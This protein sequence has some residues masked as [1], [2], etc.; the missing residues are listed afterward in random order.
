MAEQ[1][2]EKQPELPQGSSLTDQ[3]LT[4]LGLWLKRLDA[5]R[6]LVIAETRLNLRALAVFTALIITAALVVISIWLSMLACIGVMAYWLLKS[7]LLALAI[8][9]IFQWLVL[10]RLLANIRRVYIKMGYQR[11]TDALSA[12][13]SPTPDDSDVAGKHNHAD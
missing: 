2:I 4:I 5:L 3:L 1:Q 10:W 11:T 6:E 9:T 12:I 8:V 7:L 13:V